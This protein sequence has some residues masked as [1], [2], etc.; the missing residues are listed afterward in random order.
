MK[1]LIS[2]FKTYKQ[3][4]AVLLSVLLAAVLDLTN[5]DSA[6]HVVLAISAG[7][8]V[9]PLVWGMIQDLRDGKWG[10]DILAATAIITSVVMGEY[11]AG[12]VIVV[13]LTG[14][15][16]LE[17]YAESRAENELTALIENKPKK[18]L[19]LK[20]GKE[21]SI[22]ISEV[23]QGDK[24]II[25]TGDIIPV[26]CV[27]VEGNANID[28]SSITGEPLAISKTVGDELL[29]G[30]INQD[31]Y[32]TV[33][34]LRSAK[35]SQ[36]ETIIKLVE[37]A[38]KS[39][40]PFVRLADHYAVPFTIIAFMIAGG[41]WIASGDS[42]RFLQVLVVATPCP[43][44]IGAPIAIISGM[45]RA[46]R[47][48]IIIKNGASLEQLA[49][50]KTFAFDKTGT[51][52]EGRPKVSKVYAYAKYTNAQVVSLAASLEQ[53]SAH[54]LARTIV[55]Y[56]TE[57]GDKVIKAKNLKEVAG[58]GLTAVVSGKVVMVGRKDFLE[59]NNVNT[60][61][62]AKITDTAVYIGVGNELVGIMT[63][64]DE[65][66]HNS[67]ATIKGLRSMGIKNFMLV[68]GDKS[69]AV[70]DI[71][72]KLGISKVFG[73]SLPGD[74]INAIESAKNHPVV[75]VGDGVNDAPVLTAADVGIA[76]GAR[77]S[78]AASE[79]AN[80]VIM[81]DDVMRVA[82][83]TAISRR[84]LFI[85]KQS[86]MIGIIMS[87]VLMLVFA[88]GKFKPVY[89]AAIQEVVDVV[90]IIAALRAHG[91]FRK[92]DTLLTPAN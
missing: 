39:Q 42:L 3:L 12:I 53:Q 78:A 8:N 72:K 55:E 49:S 43:L 83:A 15:E 68:S 32:L 18:A 51:L 79:S 81:V 90:V 4:G 44:L 21:K 88:T 85:A 63:F 14:G 30:S 71:A 73:G 50:A 11:W 36:Y 65:L 31:G 54:V 5:K 61:T 16:A 70:K 82:T 37:A 47:H 58:Q 27:I 41:A 91:S 20:S 57:N 77:G 62:K 35:D 34:A 66:R 7:I 84:T 28:E 45:S 64:T 13:M 80:V 19:L 75:F 86:I 25:K 33:Q 67:A 29:S 40:A 10:V 52:T 92:K 23:A 89:G 9:V 24:L 60:S 59:A 22:K 69:Q 76:L 46:A 6:S 48:G 56:A 17:D 1:K 74:K 2:F 26:D 87:I 38:R